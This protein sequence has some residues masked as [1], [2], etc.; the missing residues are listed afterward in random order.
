MPFKRQNLKKATESLQAF[1][2]FS[3]SP[4][5]ERYSFPFLRGTYFAYR[6]IDVLRVVSI[7]NSIADNP[8][9][10]DIGCGYGDFLKKIREFIPCA[11]GIEKDA[12]IFYGCGISK[13]E[14]IRIADAQL[15]I[16]QK[17]DL[18]FVGW[19]D[20]S[21]DFRDQVSAKTDVIVTTLDKG[22]SLGAEFDAHGFDRI[23]TWRTPSWEDV[24]TEIMN[25]YYTK[26]SDEI[27]QSLF[28]LRSANNLWY[29]YSRQPNK[30]EAIKSALSHQLIQEKNL[31]KERYEFEDVLDECGFK[32]LENLDGDSSKKQA[33]LWDINFNLSF[34]GKQE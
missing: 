25:R 6:K 16:D 3:A 23:A 13:P 24:N 11:I 21:V 2:A 18:I 12:S 9:Y 7:A 4:Y 31:I 19:M 34:G 29:V 22:I 8:K 33:R 32:Y 14:Y 30:S 15:G 10:L 20:P 27:F 1:R 26:M 28:R 17:Y 5:H